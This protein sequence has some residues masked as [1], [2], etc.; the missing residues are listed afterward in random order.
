M[1]FRIR[2]GLYILDVQPLPDLFAIAEM[3]PH[4][5]PHAGKRLFAQSAWSSMHRGVDGKID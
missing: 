3:N 2:C 5:F 1:S 4:L